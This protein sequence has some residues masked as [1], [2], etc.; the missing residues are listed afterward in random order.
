MSKL[1]E[2]F[3]YYSEKKLE[4]FL[5]FFG[6]KM[7]LLMMMMGAYYVWTKLSLFSL[8]LVVLKKTRLKLGL[9]FQKTKQSTI[10]THITHSKRIKNLTIKEE[11]E[12]ERKC[13]NLSLVK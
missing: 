11:G 9:F 2:F 4:S 5:F 3:D 10:Y 8:S 7:H 6:S 12:R 1:N 13:A